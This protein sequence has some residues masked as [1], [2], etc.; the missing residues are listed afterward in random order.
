MLFISVLCFVFAVFW[1]HLPHDLHFSEH[2]VSQVHQSNN[3][4][5]TLNTNVFD[6]HPVHALLHKTKN[7]LHA[8][9]NF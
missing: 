5:N 9:A 2:V 4:C 7:V 1:T 3:R 8:R 6:F